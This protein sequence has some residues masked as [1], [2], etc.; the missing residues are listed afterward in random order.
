LGKNSTEPA[1]AELIKELIDA[2]HL[3]IG[4]KGTVSYHLN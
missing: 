1:V 2:G 3:S 4:D